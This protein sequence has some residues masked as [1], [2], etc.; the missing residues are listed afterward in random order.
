LEVHVSGWK[1][2]VASAALLLSQLHVSA[3]DQWPQW[4]GPEMVGVGAESPA[5]PDH[6]SR[7]DNLAWQAPVPGLGWSSPIIW[8]NQV[9][10]TTVVA[11]VASEGPKKG[12]YLPET[13]TD[14]PPDLPLGRHQWKVYS[15]D[16]AT[17]KV[18]WERVVH[19]GDA[20]ASRHPKNSY[21]SET[22]VTDGKRL[23]V[24]FGNLGLFTYDLD[25]KLLWSARVEPQLDQWGWGPG[26]SP[27]L[28]DGQVIVVLDN[29]RK[30]SIVSYD[31]AT[32]RQ[33][34]RVPRDE[35]HNWATPFAWRNSLRT[36]IVT[37]GQRQVRSY[38]LSGRLLWHF[39]G[40]LTDVSIP[41]PV[42]AHGMI[43]ISSGYPGNEHRPVF[44]I[45]PGGNGDLTVKFGE[46]ASPFIGWYQ[47]R[48]GSY[49]PSPLVYG[50]YYYTLL[51]GGFL[52][53]H[54]ARTGAEIYG[55]QRIA[56]G[57]TFTASP[58]AYQGKLFLLSEDGD[59]YVVQAGREFQVLGKNPLDE[60]TLASPAMA[61]GY[62]VL[63]TASRVYAFKQQR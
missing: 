40:K 47:P 35:G 42:A 62:L 58:W 44:A 9:F 37:T 22:P 41:T 61:S 57:A 2:L 25:G 53:C 54:D 14:R 17:G 55:R 43:Y 48:V 13:G 29:D 34:W 21:A 18:Q 39:S 6:W 52:T 51:D 31:A 23:H 4:R 3:S 49:N 30:S 33:N 56:S 46:E 24:F 10:V 36:E 63:R 28:V 20:I 12:L 15:L 45:R 7:T 59:T 27:I 16:L 38:D 8:G 1:G 60:L 26:A 50:D 5:L 32:G 11:A 19:Q